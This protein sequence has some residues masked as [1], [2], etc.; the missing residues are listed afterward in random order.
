MTWEL[1]KQNWSVFEEKISKHMKHFMQ[2]FQ[3]GMSSEEEADSVEAFFKEHNIA[4][5][6]MAVPRTIEKIR[7]KSNWMK[8]DLT[9]ITYYLKNIL[10]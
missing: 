9:H 4:N 1:F 5:V 2:G 8:R 7:Q 3:L 10:Y 6:V